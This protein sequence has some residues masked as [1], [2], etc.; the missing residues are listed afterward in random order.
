MTYSILGYG[1]ILFIIALP[2]IIYLARMRR[3]NAQMLKAAEKG[4]L[5]SEGPRAQHPHIDIST[6]IGCGSCVQVCPEGDVLALIGGKAVIANGHKCIGH[7]LCAE[8]CPVT[9]IEM[10]M[11]APGMSGDLPYLTLEHESNIHNL[12]IAGELGGLALIKNA[13]TQG[14]ECIDTVAE[15]I[16]AGT[17]KQPSTETY[18]VC[19]IGA[20]PAGISASLRAIEKKLHYLTLEQSEI[21]GT[22]AKY[23]RQ[24]L[25]MTSPVQFPLYGKFRKMALSKEELLAFWEQVGSRADFI[26][27]TNEKVTDI[28]REPDGFFTVRT[29]NGQFRAYAV[30]LALGR[31]GDP[32]KLEIPG[33]ELPKV[34]YRLIEAEAYTDN[35]ILVV[36]GGDSAV[37]S[38]LGLARQKGN[39]VY[40]SYRRESFSRIKDRN[41]RLLE[42]S[43]HSGK[44]HVLFK[45]N[46]VEIRESTVVLDCDGEKREIPNDFVWIFAGGLP[47]NAFLK[48]I[49]IQFGV[50]S[51]EPSK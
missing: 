28:K 40:L 8:A 3:K 18:E 4:R 13:I 1:L 6:C 20:G 44:I 2:L 42:E 29:S 38:S 25:V 10:R 17:M 7:G 45:S 16:A 5:Y 50:Q 31:N 48:Q 36:G 21:G 15:R 47:P 32:R 14:R 30:I 19:I 9:A 35:N 43:M 23:P 46:L 12:F 51:V 27:R 34:M 22:V 24:K 39:K 26:A 11:A 37:E 33:E 49:G 41:A